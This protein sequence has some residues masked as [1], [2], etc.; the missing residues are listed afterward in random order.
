MQDMEYPLH[1][2]LFLPRFTQ[3]PSLNQFS[4][5]QCVEKESELCFQVLGF[6][7]HEQTSGNPNHNQHKEHGLKHP[8]LSSQTNSKSAAIQTSKRPLFISPT[9]LRP[10]TS[11]DPTTASDVST[12]NVKSELS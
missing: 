6:N 10:T 9:S 12:K 1:L 8:K 7:N 5:Y 11:H 4:K 2:L 3:F